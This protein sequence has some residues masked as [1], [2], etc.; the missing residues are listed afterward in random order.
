MII[1][2]PREHPYMPELVDGDILMSQREWEEFEG[3]T[4]AQYRPRTIFEF[5]AMCDLAGARHAANARDAACKN[6]AFET[7]SCINVEAMKFGP[8]GEVNFTRL[9]QEEGAPQ[10]TA[11]A[12]QRPKLTVIS[13]I[14]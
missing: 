11:E 6:L 7:A 2:D 10:E 14:R 12:G 1:T 8:K 13:R 4:Q 3:A 9:L 5:N